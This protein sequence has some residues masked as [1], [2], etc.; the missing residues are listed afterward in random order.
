[1]HRLLLKWP[2]TALGVGKRYDIIV[3]F[4]RFKLGDKLY[5]FNVLGHKDGKGPNKE[6]DLAD[7]LFGRYKGDPTVEKFPEFR[8]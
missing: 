2:A 6:I 5:F 7:I 1:M 4:S 8:V 3:D